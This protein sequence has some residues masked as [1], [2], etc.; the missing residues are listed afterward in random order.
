MKMLRVAAVL[1]SA[2]VALGVMVPGASATSCVP[3]EAPRATITGGGERGMGGKFFEHYDGAVLG[4]VATIKSNPQMVPGGTKITV[5]VA[6]AIG[7]ATIGER[8]VV[9]AD[10]EGAMNGFPFVHGTWY[11]I[12]IQNQGPQ[13]QVNYSFL[14]DPIGELK[15]PEAAA[16][17][18]DLARRE[19]LTVAVPGN[20][21]EAEP[22][23]A[24]A[25]DDST[26]AASATGIRALPLLLGAAG[27]VT[28]VLLAAVL[29]VR[30]RRTA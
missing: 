24:P 17:L 13:G 12:P 4:K 26:G 9:S 22:D 25:A 8:M 27:A 14:C 6:G 10:D 11:F 15:G 18:L 5:E 3:A 29:V 30:R 21:A 2:A 19:G 20:G 7:A 16:A 28:A 1:L 23:A